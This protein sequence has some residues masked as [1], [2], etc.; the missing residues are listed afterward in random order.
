MDK[1]A[2]PNRARSVFALCIGIFTLLLLAP[3]AANAQVAVKHVRVTVSGPGSTAVYC[4]TGTSCP[5]GIQVWNL[6]SGITLL[7]GQTLVLT[8]TAFLA[9]IGGNFDT[10]DRVTNSP[11]TITE[12]NTNSPC[13]V[14][15]ELD[16]GSGF[17]QPVYVNSSG[18]ELDFFNNDLGNNADEHQP[19][20]AQPVFSAANYTLRL[21]YADNAHTC[22]SNCFPNPWDGSAG[23]TA[24]TFFIGAGSASSGICTTGNCYDAGALLITGVTIAGPLVTVTQGGWGAPPHGNNPGAI[25][26]A[27]FNSVFGAG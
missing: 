18:N 21:G 13:T 24:A 4:D 14:T 19:W 12:C 6:G 16:T 27:N 25:L 15:I 23:T 26:A 8:Q 7:G 5:N 17:G 2:S 11:P 22:T 10:S 3:I 1:H 20:S 9:G